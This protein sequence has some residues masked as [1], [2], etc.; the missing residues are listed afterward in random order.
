MRRV[1]AG[2]AL[3]LLLCAAAGPAGAAGFAIYEQGARAMGGAGAFT[4]RADDPSAIYFNPA[5][6]AHLEG[7]ALLLSPNLI[8]YKS[9]FAGTAPAPGFGVEEETKGQFFPPISLYYAHSIYYARS[10]GSQ[11]AAGIGV[12]NPYGLKVEWQDPDTFTGRRISTTSRITPFYFV[13]TVAWAPSPQWRVGAGA[14]LVL[15]TVELRRHLQAYNPFDDRTDDIGRLA[16]ESDRGFGAGFNA[17]VQWWPSTTMRWGATYRSKVDIDYEGD[18]D[19]T[20]VSSGNP[21]FDAAVAA[22]FPSD[23]RFATAVAFPAQ[24]SFGVARRLGDAWT[25]EVDVNWTQW[26]SF[27]R[28]DLAFPESPGLDESIVEDWKDA[29]NVRA[30]VEHR[31]AGGAAPWAWRAGYYFDESPQPT[32][33]VGPLLPDADRHGFTG[34]LGWRGASTA[35]DGYLLYVHAADRSTEG[36]NRD[37]YDG[38]YS[39]RSIVGGVSL[40]LTFR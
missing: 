26:S 23:Q 3:A 32:E 34:G 36:R 17:G 30:G 37:G 27:D 1:A 18:A 14:N 2:A 29:W 22:S 15:S 13:P 35:V 7:G 12:Y 20:Q 6:L 28:L 16:L 19:F 33:G 10:I 21:V 31:G 11:V 4:A 9:E 5:G 25:A 40:G 24:A 38:T 39:S 8:H